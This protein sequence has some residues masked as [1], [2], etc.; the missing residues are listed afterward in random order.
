M[1]YHTCFV[2]SYQTITSCCFFLLPFPSSLQK[3]TCESPTPAPPDTSARSSKKPT[4][5]R[6][7]L[8]RLNDLQF[9]CYPETAQDQIRR[10]RAFLA[11]FPLR[12]D[13]VRSAVCS[14]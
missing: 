14:W 8:N 6:R 4:N 7:R 13:V 5:E 3:P 10:T 12:G 1:R 9:S 2:L 11:G